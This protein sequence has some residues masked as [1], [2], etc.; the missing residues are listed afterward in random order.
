MGAALSGGDALKR[1][2]SIDEIGRLAELLLSKASTLSG[3]APCDEKCA[4]GKCVN[5]VNNNNTDTNA[6]ADCKKAREKAK[7]LTE[8]QQCG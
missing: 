1:A 7:T 4:D 8:L 3:K 2:L 5:A 6:A